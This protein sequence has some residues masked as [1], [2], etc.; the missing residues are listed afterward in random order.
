MFCDAPNGDFS[1][2]S[3]SPCLESAC[4][5]M[6]AFGLGCY[7]DRP[8]IIDISDVGNDNGKQVR[9]SWY[10]SNQ[11]AQGTPFSGYAVYRRQDAFAM[12]PA[13]ETTTEPGTVTIP[14]WDYLTTVPHHWDNEYQTVVPTLCDSTIT[15]GPCW[16]AF[17]V[18][19][20]T[21]TDFYDSPIDS[22]YSRDNLAPPTPSS[23]SVQ[24]NT[25]SGNALIWDAVAA[26]DWAGFRVYRAQSPGVPPSPA[27]L[28]HSTSQTAWS[29][30]DFDGWNVYYRVT[31]FDVAG[32]ESDP[33]SSTP[34][35]GVNL[36]T[37]RALSL[38]PNYPN[39]FNPSTRIPFVVPSAGRVTM[40]VYDV[41]G[42]RVSVLVDRTYDAGQHWAE[43]NGNNDAG[44]PV[45]S[46]IYVV[47]LDHRDDHRAMK[48][49]VTK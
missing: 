38:G 22:G 47:R 39:P 30:P 8:R 2:S 23:F 45:S 27:T 46:G 40:T 28:V 35:T 33:T 6:G 48:L 26:G 20:T 43:W 12:A 7:D 1:L 15:A 32:N 19:A 5:T 13:R 49:T 34:V 4:G 36:K 31:A 21:P 9:L 41:S 11:D 14:G 18:V 42:R 44:N 3:I 24:Y 29:D 37:G 17:L 16:S 10:R 25:G